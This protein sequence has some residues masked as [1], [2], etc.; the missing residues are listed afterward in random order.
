MKASFFYPVNI[1]GIKDTS[2][3]LV[4]LIP[5]TLESY[6][7]QV[8]AND[9]G[10]RKAD[11]SSLTY[12]YDEYQRFMLLSDI[13]IFDLSRQS[14][15]I[16]AST[17][18]TLTHQIPTLVLVKKDSV[19]FKTRYPFNLNSEFLTIGEYTDEKSYQNHL[20][21]FIESTLNNDKTRYNLVI[22]KKLDQYLEWA[23]FQYKK[24]KTEVIQD[25]IDE[26]SV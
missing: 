6:K 21:K 25:S 10:V 16:G 11:N 17:M 18:F 4:S 20:V 2:Y 9:L 12:S 1:D 19:N 15:S 22:N 14:T 8:I 26:Y 5:K 7:I 24:S 23:A 3:E 13:C